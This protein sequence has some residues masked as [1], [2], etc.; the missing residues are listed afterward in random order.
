MSQI[1][2]WGAGFG[3]TY[4]FTTATGTSAQL[5][6]PASGLGAPIFALGGAY[7]NG[8]PFQIHLA[9]YVKSHGTSQTMQVG[10]QAQI[11]SATAAF[12][13]TSLGLSTAS[14]SMTAGTSYPFRALFDCVSDNAS[15]VLTGNFWAYDGVTPTNK[16]QAVNANLVTGLA[17][18]GT[19]LVSAANIA[20]PLASAGSPN[21]QFAP[22]IV[23]GVSD[24]ATVFTITQFYATTD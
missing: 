4:S 21:I 5:V 24:T 8:K 3:N 14:G 19:G 18:W 10:V 11:Y 22:Q 17:G 20:N 16:V 6:A 23:N 2:A 7:L 1:I 12:S 15:L 9:G 13:G